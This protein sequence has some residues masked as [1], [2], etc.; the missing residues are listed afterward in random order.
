MKFLFT[1]I[2]FLGSF[3]VSCNDGAFPQ[4]DNPNLVDESEANLEL[5]LTL[6]KYL[7]SNFVYEGWLVTLGSDVPH[8]IGTFSTA[9]INPTNTKSY[10]FRVDDD[11]LENATSFFISIESKNDTDPAPSKSIVLEGN[12]NLGNAELSIA[13]I[14]DFNPSEIAGSFFLRTP[15]DEEQVGVNNGNDQF[16]VWF[17]IPNEPPMSG[18]VL[19]ELRRGE[20]WVYEGWVQV[21]TILL[22]TGKFVFFNERDINAGTP[23]SFSA[24]KSLGPKIPGEDFFNKTSNAPVGVSFPLDVRNRNIFV[25]IEP[26]PD[27]DEKEFFTGCLFGRSD[28]I[29]LDEATPLRP[30]LDFSPFGNA[31]KR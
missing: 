23:S 13:S 20:G 1:S 16:G 2:V 21:G 9:R 28:G 17:G 11:L 27:N 26:Y 18:F 30:D 8:S 6:M 22:S 10:F 24:N 7:G 29:T 4:P 12:F 31:I 19:P 5:D 25:S 15:T 14:A 3:L